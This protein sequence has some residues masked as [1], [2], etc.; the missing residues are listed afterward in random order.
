M[1]HVEGTGR[2]VY[3]MEC[4]T[5]TDALLCVYSSRDQRAGTAPR[6]R[7]S[8]RREGKAIMLLPVWEKAAAIPS[9]TST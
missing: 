2:R 5:R 1:D 3:L 8:T 4:S 9:Y 7:S 6:M